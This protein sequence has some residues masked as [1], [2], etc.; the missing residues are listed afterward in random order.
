MEKYGPATREYFQ[1]VMD[2][3]LIIDQSYQACQGLMRLA[4]GY[5][6]RIEA[7]CVRA[8]KG[9]RFNYMAIKNI[10]DNNMD[11]LEKKEAPKQYTI[12]LHDNIRG[13]GEYK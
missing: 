1:R 11:L 13:A 3:K 9:Q 8:L 6:E 7:A 12:P 4:T 5:P 10:L 2:S